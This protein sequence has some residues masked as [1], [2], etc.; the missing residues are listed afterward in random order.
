MQA[1]IPLIEFAYNADALGI[2]RPNGEAYAVNT[3]DFDR[4][5]TQHTIALTQFPR[6][7]QI[8]IFW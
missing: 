7:E 3:V 1:A 6:A 8:Q 2:R 4:V 5:R